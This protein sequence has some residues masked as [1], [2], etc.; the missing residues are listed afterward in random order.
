MPMRQKV[1]CIS[2][3]CTIFHSVSGN[4]NRL[5][6][7]FQHLSGHST[8]ST[9]EWHPTYGS[10]LVLEPIESTNKRFFKIAGADLTSIT[11][12][13]ES[14]HKSSND[15]QLKE[16]QLREF[17]QYF[18]EC[19]PQSSI[20]SALLHPSQLNDVIYLQIGKLMTFLFTL[21]SSILSHFGS[22]TF[23]GVQESLLT[24]TI[25][26]FMAVIT[27]S[28][29]PKGV[30]V[31]I[32]HFSSGVESYLESLSASQCDVEF[33][34]RLGSIFFPTIITLENSFVSKTSPCVVDERD[35]L[36]LFNIIL[37][38]D[39]FNKMDIASLPSTQLVNSLYSITRRCLIALTAQLNL[40]KS[41]LYSI[42]TDTN[43]HS[44]R[45]SF[46][47]A[48]CGSES[49]L[50]SWDRS[51]SSEIVDVLVGCISNMAVNGCT[52][53]ADS[54]SIVN[55]ILSVVLVDV[56]SFQLSSQ[57]RQYLL[58][59]IRAESL[60]MDVYEHSLDWYGSCSGQ[61]SASFLYLLQLF[62][63]FA[64]LGL[65]D[66]V[67]SLWMT[68]FIELGFGNS[69]FLEATSLLSDDKLEQLAACGIFPYFLRILDVC[70]FD[71]NFSVALGTHSSMSK[72]DHND[73]NNIV[74]EDESLELSSVFRRINAFKWR[75]GYSFSQFINSSHML[76]PQNDDELDQLK[77][78][79][80][81]N[82]VQEL[83]GLRY[84]LE[85]PSEYAYIS[86]ILPWDA[87]VKSLT[88]EWLR[89]L[90][91]AA[92]KDLNEVA[93]D[94]EATR[95]DCIVKQLVANNMFRYAAHHVGAL[96]FHSATNR[97]YAKPL[98]H[99]NEASKIN[100]FVLCCC[101][102]V[103]VDSHSVG[104]VS[105]LVKRSI[106]SRMLVLSDH[107][108]VCS[109]IS[110]LVERILTLSDSQ[111]S[112]SLLQFLGIPVKAAVGFLCKSWFL[113]CLCVEDVIVISAVTLLAGS[114]SFAS[115]VVCALLRRVEETLLGGGEVVTGGGFEVFVR[116]LRLRPARM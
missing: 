69:N 65:H 42:T 78:Y 32:E 35:L 50:L 102:F 44:C 107:R 97:E 12:V 34:T 103:G 84:S 109:Q 59:A 38:S 75:C 45:I 115:L 85:I 3:L 66:T 93:V 104:I 9:A 49:L 86:R 4:L 98:G 15:S 111:S 24:A 110:T 36:C 83:V 31:V 39:L 40:D 20:V 46:I 99:T 27:V 17:V 2:Q 68:V 63:G 37:V 100:F 28:S 13:F 64:A 52:G 73:E 88:L 62:A 112:L 10:D 113:S 90:C 74:D 14:Y 81:R 25:S 57:S 53:F 89:S 22:N 47:T 11:T 72:M 26:L 116:A 55:A 71:M 48:L 58:S 92:L 76:L 23:K 95:V 16:K 54:S 82:F 43:S 106:S 7:I 70:S 96:L 101:M 91:V 56:D 6:A 108:S 114:L 77:Y 61:D 41:S 8:L 5:C 30:R 60:G 67:L 79:L 19:L 87:T 33:V 80:H 18:I 21:G 1:Y 105:K 29:D 51:V 94:E